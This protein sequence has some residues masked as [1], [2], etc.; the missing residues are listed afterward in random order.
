MKKFIFFICIFFCFIL[1]SCNSEQTSVIKNAQKTIEQ[2]LSNKIS[3]YSCIYNN[4]NQMVYV[5]FHSDN[6]GNDEALI[7]L[8]NYKV[9]YESVY[10][11][12]SKDD[13]D[14]IIEYGD[15]TTNIYQIQNGSEDWQE[16]KVSK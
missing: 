16:I 4:K 2:D 9:Y 1:T 7:D 15:Y 3:I 5:K 6:T 13:Y 11:S 8:K 12:I 10:L 14:K